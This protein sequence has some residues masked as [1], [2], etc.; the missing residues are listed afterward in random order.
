MMQ[1]VGG[2]SGVGLG[3][4][5]SGRKGRTLRKHKR[6]KYNH[7]GMQISKPEI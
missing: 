7:L 2:A 3:S 1:L 6:G 5:R 4:G